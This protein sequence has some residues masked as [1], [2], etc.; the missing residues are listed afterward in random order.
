MTNQ[1][2]DYEEFRQRGVP[3][4]FIAM[5]G[6]IIAYHE[7]SHELTCSFPV[8]AEYLNPM[9][10]MQGGFIAA[11]IDNVFGPLSLLAGGKPSATVQM[12]VMYHRPVKMGDNLV[13]TSRVLKRGRKLL[14]M[15]AQALNGDGELVANA[16]STW[17]YVV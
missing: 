4:C 12:Q 14:S 10:G 15:E 7:E 17:M 2:M 9:Q 5:E 11:A 1:G 3:A 13:I 6:E 8:K 16:S